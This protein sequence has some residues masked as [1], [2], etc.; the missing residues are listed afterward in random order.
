[1]DTN[2]RG[3]PHGFV[4]TQ[5]ISST[6]NTVISSSTSGNTATHH[7]LIWP[8]YSGNRLYQTLGNLFTTPKAGLVIPDLATG[9]ALYVTGTTTLHFGAD[10]AAL[11]PRSNL[12]VSLAIT[13]SRFVR[14]GLS[15]CAL[16]TEDV[17]ISPYTPRL[18]VL[19]SEMGAAQSQRGITKNAPLATLLSQTRLSPTISRFRFSLPGTVTWKPGQYVV[20]DFSAELA[21]GYSHMRDDDPRSLNDDFVRTFTVSSTPP[22]EILPQ[23][24]SQESPRPVKAQNTVFEVTMRRIAD[25][26]VTD[27]LFR[28]SLGERRSTALPLEIGVLGFEGVFAFDVGA[29]LAESSRLLYVASGVGITPLLA[30][31]NMLAAAGLVGQLTLFWTLK[32]EDAGFA[33][34]VID[35][36]CGHNKRDGIGETTGPAVTLFITGNVAQDSVDGEGKNGEVSQLEEKCSVLRRRFVEHDFQA[37]REAGEVSEE[38]EQVPAEQVLLC[39]NPPLTTMVQQWLKQI[40]V[41]VR[42]E[43]FGY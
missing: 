23:S 31:M 26:P 32:V 6:S 43:G 36:L 30:Q 5:L 3:G 25:G 34:D 13:A 8:E 20:L 15:F 38:T 41:E 42:S 29:R 40:G 10:A 37:W 2:Y 12:V 16:Q 7:E 18:R 24:Q 4:R 28:Q 14:T 27:F 19:A 21:I 17:D 9:D 33:L 11:I 39:A 35:V 1:M 22:E